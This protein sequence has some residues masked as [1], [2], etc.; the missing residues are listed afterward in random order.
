MKKFLLG[1]IVLILFLP[2]FSCNN[3]KIPDFNFIYPQD[4]DYVTKNSLVIVEFSDIKN[5]KDL[6]LMITDE[7]FARNLNYEI[8]DNRIYSSL[9]SDISDGEY[10]I[11]V[12]F[13]LNEKSF[14]KEINIILNSE[15]PV[16]ENFIYPVYI[17]SG[18]EIHV[19]SISSYPLKEVKAY[20]DDGTILNLDYIEEKDLWFG[21][22][23]I[24]NF[25]SEGSHIVKFVGIDLKGE[26][27]EDTKIFYIINSD[28]VIYSP[29]DGLETTSNEI[30]IYGFYEQDKNIMIYLNN[31]PYK[32]IKVD[33]DGNF[34]EN[35][36]LLPG[37]YTIFAKDENSPFIGQSSLQNIRIKIFND[38]VIVLCY[39]NIEN[40]G[41]NLYTITPQDFE[42]Q[43]K[44]MIDKGYKSISIDELYDYYFNGKEIPKKSV[45]ITFDD[46]LKGV[47]QYAYPIL[48]KY[49][50]KATF[51]VI[52]G[53]VGR[54]K[55]YV[56]WNELKEMVQSGVFSIGSHTFDSHKTYLVEGKY[57]SVI[58]KKEDDENYEN[59]KNRVLEDFYNSKNEIEKNIDK[60][61]F[62]FAYPYGEFSIDTINF[63]KEANF[64]FAFTVIKEII[65]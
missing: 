46:G 64:K 41:G 62:A 54:V 6:K 61:I 25:L 63:L 36:I 30:T 11:M 10:R 17:R 26:R 9:P 20:F 37:N 42:N 27:L 65:N 16:W 13:Y 35:L 52:V 32:E 31:R 48:K 18:R 7:R 19:E 34:L 33:A 22:L 50:F 40:K 5:L 38:G 14:K 56:N 59:F 57:I 23:T 4:G 39:H 2:F 29:I 58:T 44:Y 51:F 49:G 43:I 24:S 47:Y 1:G 60:E 21:N 55:N 53:R 15:V 3:S 45:L 28:P 12:S 8:K